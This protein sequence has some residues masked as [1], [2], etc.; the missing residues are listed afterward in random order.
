MKAAL[1]CGA[2][3]FFGSHLVNRLKREGFRVRGVDLMF[4]ELSETEADDFIVAN[5]PD[6]GSCRAIVDHRFDEV[7][8]LAPD[9][10][11]AGDIFT[12][13]HD[14]DTMHNS[15]MIN[16]NIL[17]PCKNRNSRR[18]FCSSLACISPEGNQLDPEAP[19]IRE[20][21]AYPAAPESD[22]DFEKLFSER[23]NPAYWR[24]HGMQ[25]RVAH[26]NN[27][28]G[29]EGTWV[30]GGETA[31]AGMCRKIAEAAVDG[32]IEMWGD[33]E[34]TRSFMYVDECLD[35]STCL[36]RSDFVG[37]VNIRSEE[38]VTINQIA[39]MVMQVAGEHSGRPRCLRPQ[40]AHRSVREGTGLASV[41]EVDRRQSQDLSSD[42]GPS[43]AAAGPQ[44]CLRTAHRRLREH[45][46]GAKDEGSRWR[47]R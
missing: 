42:P 1:V 35:A 10:G 25:V 26:Y 34:Q 36:P 21:S 30:A 39:P 32:S 43:E 4:P 22:H 31:P 33:G 20:D 46:A 28:F 13:M 38:I 5:L 8:Q 15:A 23:L 29:P 7:Y 40:F 41:T 12:G 17:W 45:P 14:A 2:G 6:S 24:N 47:S 27:I 19:I 3:G 37:P 9:M 11:G 44:P 18:I 16:L